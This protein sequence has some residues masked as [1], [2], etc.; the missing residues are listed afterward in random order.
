MPAKYNATDLISWVGDIILISDS[1]DEKGATMKAIEIV[2]RDMTSLELERMNTGFEKNAIDNGVIPQG[3]KRF[4]YVAMDGENF[5]GCV[6]GLAYKN[7]EEFNGWCYLTDLFVEKEY[8]LQGIGARLL[9][10]L[11]RKLLEQGIIK[12]WTWTAGYEALKFYEKQ[13]Y[14]VF[15]EMENW[16]SNGASQIGLRKNLE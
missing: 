13:G 16:Y 6:S 5:I 14:E 8:R 4:G 10:A 12:I 15:A 2:E 7:G 9:L 1:Y 3:D 11:E